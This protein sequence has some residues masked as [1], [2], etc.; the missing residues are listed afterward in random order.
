MKGIVFFLVM[1]VGF[2]A[3]AGDRK[4]G[5]VVA[6][7]REVSDVYETCLKKTDTDGNKPKPFYSCSFKYIQ[8]GEMALT[9]GRIVTLID[10]RCSVLG[11]ALN[12]NVIMTYSSTEKASGFESARTCLA[13]ALAR[14][15]AG[16][17]SVKMLVYT[18][19]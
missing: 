6:V 13:R 15:L 10:D 14:A 19:E 2:V 1:A 16:K 5:T 9:S 12:G 11:E 4:L 17:D 7:E 18:V 8:D 3:N